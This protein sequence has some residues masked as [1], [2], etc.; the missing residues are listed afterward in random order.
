V[1]RIA[2][3]AT[4]CYGRRMTT[5]DAAPAAGWT[6]SAVVPNYNH[7]RH[8]SAAVTA[9]LAQTHPPE[10]II[11]VDDGST[12]ESRDVIG[13][14]VALDPRVRAVFHG[15]NRGAIAALNSGIR[16]ATGRLVYLG[17]ADDV[18]FPDLIEGLLEAYNLAPEAGLCCAELRQLDVE[19]GAASLRPAA[20]PSAR[21][22]AFSVTETQRLFERND[23]FIMTGA[24]L[25]DREKL[26]AAGALRP[27]LGSFADGFAVRQ[28]A[29][30][31]GFVFVPKVLA[32][33]RVSNAGL[34]RRTAADPTAVDR[35]V[36]TM[37]TAIAQDR[38]FPEGYGELFARRWKFGVMR[39]ALLQG[40]Q[41]RALVESR[42]P[43][44]QSLRRFFAGLAG[45]AGPGRYAALAW[46]TFAY[47]PF[48]LGPIIATALGRRR[49]R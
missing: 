12:D 16:A 41:G 23:N 30:R 4:E 2:Y 46:L 18:S 26:L 40:D 49:D 9:L 7:G 43:G 34:S 24:A 33:W 5:S 48:A 29:F 21:A 20:R 11:V 38:A 13:A 27:E 45:H 36:E 22:K 1:A 25:I 32:E 15:E 42:G 44:P 8:L 37:S 35:L 17:A 47:R 3:G 14:L 19:T 6:V 39:L 31:H 10:E 28:L